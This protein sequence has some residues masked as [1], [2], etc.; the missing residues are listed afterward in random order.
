M[1][2]DAGPG[3]YFGEIALPHDVPRTAS[4]VAQTDLEPYALGRETFVAA[5]SGHAQSAETAEA[6]ISARLAELQARA[7]RP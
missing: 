1:R 4:V 7:P 3:D 2:G 5:V 6:T